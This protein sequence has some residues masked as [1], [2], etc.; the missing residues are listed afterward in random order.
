MVWPSARRIA[1][2]PRVEESYRLAAQAVDGTF[3]PSGVNWR[4]ALAHDPTIALY[5]PD[6][7]H[8]SAAGSWLSAMTLYR[9]LAGPLPS[10][11]RER[12]AAEKAA[13]RRLAVTDAQLLM[14][15]DLAN[16]TGTIAQ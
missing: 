10:A 13:A 3:V 11:L 2:F 7:Y 9:T 16:G 12:R 6:G 8:P 15:F 4:R 1:D 5:G 14:L